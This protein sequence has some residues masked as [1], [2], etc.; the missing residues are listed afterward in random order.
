MKYTILFYIA[1][2]IPLV[3][4][5]QDARTVLEQISKKHDSKQGYYYKL[6]YAFFAEGQKEPLETMEGISCASKGRIYYKAGPLETLRE[7]GLIVVLQHEDKYLLIGKSG[8]YAQYGGGSPSDMLGQLATAG[9]SIRVE[10][11]SDGQQQLSVYAPQNGALQYAL[12]YDAALNVRRIVVYYDEENSIEL[13]GEDI[14]A[15]RLEVALESVPDGKPPL[16]L[17]R[18]VIK[19]NG[20]YQPMA[21]YKGYQFQNLLLEEGD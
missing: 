10:K 20:A 15:S 11:T 19:K 16:E 1:A 12:V 5:A 17:A 18:V 2:L 21:A 6:R 7:E 8:H 3:G 14:K 4:E 13:A 9:H